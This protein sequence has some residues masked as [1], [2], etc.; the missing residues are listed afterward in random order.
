MAVV[1]RIDQRPPYTSEYSDVKRQPVSSQRL[2]AYSLEGCLKGQR[3]RDS[4]L[5]R[6][7]SG[8]RKYLTACNQTC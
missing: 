6:D 8:Q 5:K 2:V 3:L 7:D 1:L 4:G